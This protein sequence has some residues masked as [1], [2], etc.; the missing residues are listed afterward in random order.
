VRVE[1]TGQRDGHRQNVM[2]ITS[3]QFALVAKYFWPG[4]EASKSA[5]VPR[6]VLRAGLFL[7]HGVCERGERSSSKPCALRVLPYC[8]LLWLNSA[9]SQTIC[10]LIDS[11]DMGHSM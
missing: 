9:Q 7:N 6:C 5:L 8:Q 11:C 2:T 3:Q 10:L 4:G 1:F